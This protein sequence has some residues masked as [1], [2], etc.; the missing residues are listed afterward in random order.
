MPFARPTL[1][2]LI[3][4][5][6]AE[7]ESRLPGADARTRRSNLA[8]LARVNAGAAHGLYGYI[9]WV[10]RQVFPDTADAEN[11]DRW[12]SIWAVSRKAPAFAVGTLT[13]T[14][15]VGA[16]IP[17]GSV[18]VFGELEFAVDADVT[19]A[20]GSG[21]GAVTALEPGV[22][23]NLPAG[24]ALAF[25]SP[26]AGVSAAATV[27]A[28]GLVNGADAETDA[29]LR[30]RLLDRIGQPPEGGAAH[31]YIAWALQVP[32]IT[33]AWV[34]PEEL[35]AGTVTVRVV[36]DTAAAGLIP[37]APKIAE[38]QTWIDAR[39]P[40]TAN[41]TVV[42]PIAAPLNM[43]IQLL[44]SSQAIRDAVTAEIADLLRREAVPGGT[45]LL[46]HLREAISIAAGET[47]HVLISPVANVTH[48]TGLIAVPGVIT[49]S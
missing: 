25:I 12:A 49:W 20:A 11:L 39:R 18:L 3:E 17:Q 36:S 14:G 47:D 6:Q 28:G 19:L 40:V 2:E 27:A 43:S 1:A 32:G 9:D 10:A 35:G 44:P 30:E 37:S 7:M 33:R 38:V 46:T 5:N 22:A 13:F 16:V 42:A 8:V 4:R 45:I 15:T 29:A 34:Y 23:S 31:D 24:A 48:A 21:T 26:V 41:P